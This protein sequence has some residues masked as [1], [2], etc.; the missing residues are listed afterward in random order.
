MGRSL[1][2]NAAPLDDLTVSGGLEAPE[3]EVIG[4]RLGPQS[5]EVTAELPPLLDET[6]VIIDFSAPQASI[7]ALEAAAE[8]GVG[9]VSGTTGLSDSE[10]TRFEELSSDIPVLRASNFSVGINLLMQLVSEASAATDG[11]FDL[12][13]FEAHHRHKVDAPSGT[14]LS[15]GEAAAEARGH[16]LEDVATFARQGEVG[17]RTDEE[18]GFQVMRGGS[19]VGE[20][21]VALCGEGER[22]ELSHQASDRGIFARGALRA[23][24]WLDGR[25]PDYYTMK[26]VLFG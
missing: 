20:H 13:V 9:V 14:A 7:A 8:A 18:I 4:Q 12:E 11:D 25:T 23:A 6:D 16:D 3:S 24:G 1:L 15:L 19:I 21:T 22:I 10:E 26:D 2:E 5:V 17:E